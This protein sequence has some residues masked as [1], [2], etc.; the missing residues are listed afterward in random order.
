MKKK[1]ATDHMNDNF[2]SE[3]HIRFDINEPGEEALGKKTGRHPQEEEGSPNWGRA[4]SFFP[5]GEVPL[6]SLSVEG[7]LYLME[8]TG[9][10]TE[11]L[12]LDGEK[13]SSFVEKTLGDAAEAAYLG[14]SSINTFRERGGG[15]VL[16]VVPR[17]EE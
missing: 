4:T 14:E 17:G 10:F 16:L 15:G 11:H 12:L 9:G 7:E 8:N 3:N 1:R 6:N 2:Q 5:P 13:A